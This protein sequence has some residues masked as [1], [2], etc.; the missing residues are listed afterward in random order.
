MKFTR[1]PLGPKD[2]H[3]KITHVGICHSD[4]HQVGKE[5]LSNLLQ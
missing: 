5:S 2:V 3:I 4:Y 1:R